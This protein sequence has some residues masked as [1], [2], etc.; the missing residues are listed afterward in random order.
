MKRIVISSVLVFLF[1][2]IFGQKC[3][4][5]EKLYFDS[6]D[7]YLGA[8][9]LTNK[10][11]WQL[12]SETK[13]T[14]FELWYSWNKGE[15]E[16]PVKLY[17]DGEL[18]AEFTATRSSCDP[19]QQQWCN[20]DYEINKV[21]PPGKYSTEITESRQCL[22]PGGTGAVRLYIDDS[23]LGISPTVSPTVTSTVVA[24]STTPTQITGTTCACDKSLI[25]A[26]SAITSGVVSLL[27]WLLLK[28]I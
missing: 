4:A 25:I 27:M 13:I 11:E 28:R 9:Q 6:T 12:S 16:L 7:H 18:F 23:D 15:T 2:V 3:L 5:E 26:G 20:A 22:K 24:S 14:K 10:S 17:K 8:C 19:Y 1:L 21:F